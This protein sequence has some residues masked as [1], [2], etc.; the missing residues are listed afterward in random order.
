M[1]LTDIFTYT[2]VIHAH[3]STLL[4]LQ[5]YSL[6]TLRKFL[7]VQYC[8]MQLK[9]FFRS[10]FS[11][12]SLRNC[13]HYSKSLHS[14]RDAAN[15]KPLQHRLNW[16]ETLS[17]DISCEETQ[18]KATVLIKRLDV[19][20]E[21]INGAE[22]HRCP[23][24]SNPVVLYRRRKEG[25]AI[26]W[27]NPMRQSRLWSFNDFIFLGGQRRCSPSSPLGSYPPTKTARSLHSSDSSSR[28]GTQEDQKYRKICMPLRNIEKSSI[29]ACRIH[30]LWITTVAPCPIE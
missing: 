1:Y 7:I 27:T 6:Y 28:L 18:E 26:A 21:Q 20:S 14:P 10:A 12:Q 30:A 25:R 5:K 17:N 15:S 11:L 9:R 4:Y 8:V 24:E 2:I 13:Y 16:E 22:H 23:Q 3:P 29:E 19:T